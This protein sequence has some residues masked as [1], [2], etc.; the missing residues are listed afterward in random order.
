LTKT[1][2]L[3]GKLG[4]DSRNRESYDADDVSVVGP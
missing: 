4:H 2:R 3:M 1:P